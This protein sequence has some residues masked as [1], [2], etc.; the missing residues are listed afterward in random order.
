MKK[1]GSEDAQ[2]PDRLGVGVAEPVRQVGVE[3]RDFASGEHEVLF[4]E[5]SMASEVEAGGQMTGVIDFE[6]WLDVEFAHPGGELAYAT[7]LAP[8]SQQKIDN[9]R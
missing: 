6:F 9:G 7:S 8:Q 2:V 5:Y 3:L 1:L 4:S